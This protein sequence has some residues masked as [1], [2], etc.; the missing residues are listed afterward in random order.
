M[1]KL[2]IRDKSGTLVPVESISTSGGGITVIRES[3]YLV[4]E[5]EG[6]VLETKLTRAEF[7]AAAAG[8][9]ELQVITDDGVD[10]YVYRLYDYLSNGDAAYFSR[11]EGF[12]A[13]TISIDIAEDGTMSVRDFTHQLFSGSSSVA[14][15]TLA[16]GNYSDGTTI[17]LSGNLADYDLIEIHVTDTVGYKGVLHGRYT[18]GDYRGGGVTALGGVYSSGGYIYHANLSISSSGLLYFPPMYYPSVGSS[19]SWYTASSG[20]RYVTKIVG[21]KFG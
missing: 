4:G 5:V 9:M 6:T 7:L 10:W 8:G 1:S 21:Y 17:P 20:A 2:Y 19:V 3:N 12:A 11:Q 14:R 18:A 15:K 16:E 13:H